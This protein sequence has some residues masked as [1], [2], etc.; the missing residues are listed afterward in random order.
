MESK[1]EIR[2]DQYRFSVLIPEARIR[3]AVERLGRE[4]SRD[5]ADR[6]PIFIGVLNGAIPFVADLV[7]EFDGVCEV[8]YI[9]IG[10][11]GN[12]MESTGTIKLLK[13]ISASLTDRHVIVVEDIVD[14]GLSATFLKH[15]MEETRPASVRFVAL[16]LKKQKAKLDFPIDYVGFEIGN[17]FVIGY[18][19]DYAQHY[20]NLKDIYVTKD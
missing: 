12:K 1:K 19:L 16:L 17:E 11:Y 10:S 6:N 18:G 4:I 2:I 3:E 7:R 8:D 9:K 20:R 13:D 5:Y 15:R 14:S